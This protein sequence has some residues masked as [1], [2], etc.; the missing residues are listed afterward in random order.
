MHIS[1]VPLL[2]LFLSVSSLMVRTP[3]SPNGYCHSSTNSDGSQQLDCPGGCQ[4]AT[5]SSGKIKLQQ[6]SGDCSSYFGPQPI[7]NYAGGAVIQAPDCHITVNGGGID[8][9]GSSCDKIRP[10]DIGT[11]VG[12]STHEEAPSSTQVSTS[13]TTSSSTS[14]STP[15]STQFS[16][17]S[18]TPISSPSTT[19]GEAPSATSDDALSFIHLS[20][21]WPT[22]TSPSQSIQTTLNG[23]ALAIANASAADDSFAR[24][25]ATGIGRNATAIAIARSED[26]NVTA[27]AI[28]T[29]QIQQC[30]CA[31]EN[32]GLADFPANSKRAER[33]MKRDSFYDDGDEAT[34]SSCQ[35]LR[36][37][38][39]GLMLT[40]PDCKLNIGRDLKLKSASGQCSKYTSCVVRSS[41]ALAAS[42]DHRDDDLRCTEA[43]LPDG[44]TLRTCPQCTSGMNKEGKIVGMAGERCH[45]YTTPASLAGSADSQL[46]ETWPSA[47][48]SN[49]GA[50]SCTQ[51]SWGNGETVVA[52]P[53]CTNILDCHGK[54]K[55]KFGPSCGTYDSWDVSERLLTQGKSW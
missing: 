1:L 29:A 34:C 31:N 16:T 11:S 24:A 44:K 4:Q 50:M 47:E 10:L 12:G 2:S 55:I 18:S 28:A 25:N 5:D 7:G 39:G 3:D 15:S 33:H 27:Y 32:G 13:S 17:S 22:S 48:V 38:Q 30:S 20:I 42:G 54:E 52:C 14:S 21:H 8:E 26:G 19:Q 35:A 41:M 45:E 51:I 36:Y 43:H 23:G 6:G 40:C 9:Q 46:W 49:V 53:G 37:E